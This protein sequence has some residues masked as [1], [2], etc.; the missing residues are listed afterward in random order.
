MKKLFAIIFLAV[1]FLS[2]CAPAA[3]SP[4]AAPPAPTSAPKATQAPAATVAR[5]ATAQPNT[6]LVVQNSKNEI[7]AQGNRVTGDILTDEKLGVGQMGVDYP[8]TMQLGESRSIVLKIAPSA[9]LTSLRTAPAPG[10]TTDLPDLVFRLSSKVDIY[11]VMFAELRAVNF[12]FSPKGV[13]RRLIQQN[14]EMVWSWNI[15]SQAPGAQSLSLELSIPI[16]VGGNASEL[17]VLQNLPFAINVLAPPPL[18]LTDQIL[19]SLADNAGAILVA[20]IGL[21][22]TVIGLR[23]KARADAKDARE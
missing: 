9:Q 7:T 10:K 3:S 2:A 8:V 6:A 1:I 22:G 21:F 17:S 15:A 20:L 12:D 14:Q 4:T 11:P 19:K 16:I 18:S 5:T 13:Q 23:A